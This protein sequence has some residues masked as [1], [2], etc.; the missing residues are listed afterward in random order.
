VE[1]YFSMSTHLHKFFVLEV[2]LYVLF[3]L[4]VFNLEDT[5]FYF[6]DH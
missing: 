3:V 4:V 5:K 1:A 6:L 2:S